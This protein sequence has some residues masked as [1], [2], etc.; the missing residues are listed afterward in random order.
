MSK[1]VPNMSEIRK[2]CQKKGPRNVSERNV[3]EK[4][5]KKC[6]KEIQINVHAKAMRKR[7]SHVK[8]QRKGQYICRIMFE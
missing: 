1:E 5:N 3:K 6:P 7:E 8:V 2:I 4:E